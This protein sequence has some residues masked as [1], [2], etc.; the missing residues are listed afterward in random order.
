[1]SSAQRARAWAFNN[2]CRVDRVV[3]AL[4]IAMFGVALAVGMAVPP[5]TLALLLTAVV[6]LGLLTL[7]GLLPTTALLTGSRHAL[8]AVGDKV[9]VVA[10]KRHDAQS[11][12][13]GTVQAINFRPRRVLA[14]A[15]S[16]F[17]LVDPHADAAW[18]A[19]V[20]ARD[21]V[22]EVP[23]SRLLLVADGRSGG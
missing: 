13:I 8:L 19:M 15:S 14:P 22:I 10:D 12:S 5:L 7:V 1:M 11:A 23:I 6:A 17:F 20:T 9:E 4:A 16:L 2:A 21:E 3:T 18:I